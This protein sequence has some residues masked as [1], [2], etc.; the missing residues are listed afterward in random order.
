MKVRGR[1]SWLAVSLAAMGVTGGSYAQETDRP[2]WR[3]PAVTET[4]KWAADPAGEYLPFDSAW[5]ER[6]RVGGRLGVIRD[7]GAEVTGWHQRGSWFGRMAQTP[8]DLADA[9]AI[10]D[11]LGRE[12][13]I[14]FE[15]QGAYVV[16]FDPREDRR[17][18]QVPKAWDRPAR[19]FKF[20]SLEA[21]EDGGKGEASYV[22]QR[23]S[24][25]WYTPF[26]DKDG[27]AARPDMAGA[28]GVALVMPGLFGTP[29]MVIDTVVRRLRQDNWAVLRLLSASSRFTETTEFVINPRTNLEREAERAAAELCDR[30]AEIAYAVEAA[31]EHM[32]TINPDLRGKP[33]VAI[34]GSAGAMTMSTVVAR[35]PGA[36]GAVVMIGGGADYWLINERSNYRRTADAIRIE[37]VGGEPG[38]EARKRFTEAYMKRARLDPYHTAAALKGKPVLLFYGSLD[39]AVQAA[40]GDLLWE[41]LGRPRRDV[42]PYGHE[43]LFGLVPS[44]L[45]EFSAWLI[46][47]SGAG[48]AGGA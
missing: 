40:L 39:R 16:S 44:K 12:V 1:A 21:G 32:L 7:Q 11:A 33:R 41:R 2:A 47:Q 9:R 22:I 17:Y 42:V 26:A 15:G 45:D 46:E 10:Q 25:V 6:V 48:G 4:P 29:D 3:R 37:W 19:Q 34:G 8:E 38:E 23:S 35:D 30:A 18:T 27:K 14:D 43:F 20:I 31:F 36:Y 24:F 28:R 13:K 5:P